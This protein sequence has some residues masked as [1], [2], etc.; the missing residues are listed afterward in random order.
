G[1]LA[2]VVQGVIA[3]FLARIATYAGIRRVGSAQYALLAPVE[4]LFTL[5]W[6]ALFLGESFSPLQAVGAG[7]II[8][9]LTLAANVEAVWLRL[10]RA[11]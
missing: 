7:L 6:A 11:K 8:V 4:S 1:W 5:L 9:S 2:M 3:T 10:R